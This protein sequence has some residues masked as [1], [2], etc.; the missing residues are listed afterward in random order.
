MGTFMHTSGIYFDLS[1]KVGSKPVLEGGSALNKHIVRKH[2]TYTKQ[3][4]LVKEMCRITANELGGWT[5]G[6]E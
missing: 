1:E 4:S 5:T 3:K 6:G 2:N